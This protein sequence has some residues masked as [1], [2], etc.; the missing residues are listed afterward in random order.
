MLSD[1][2][3]QTITSSQT[4]PIPGPQGVP[5]LGHIPDLRSKGVLQFYLDAWHQFGDVARFKMGPIDM[6]QFV[7]PEHV[8]H[9]LVK[10]ADNY[11]KALSHEKLRVPLGEG[12][13][14]SEGEHWRRQR[15]LMAPTFTPRAVTQF[16]DI[17]LAETQKLM[18]R[19]E[20]QPQG[21]P[22]AINQE[23]M[24]FAMS[25]ISRSMFTLDIGEEFSEAGEALSFILEFANKRTISLVDPPLFL[26][27]PMNLALKRSLRRLDGFLYGIIAERR[28][29][30]PGDDLLSILMQAKDEQT[31]TVMTDEQL[32]DEVLITFFAGHETTATLLSWAW[33]LLAQHPEPEQRLH[34]E[35]D[36]VLGGRSP[37]V[38]DRD[39]LVY[40]GMVLGE[41]LRLYS[42][43][44]VMAR[45]TVADDQIDG[46]AIPAG[47]MVTITPYITHRHPEFWE[48]PDAFYPE[49]F[50]P[51]A[52]DARHRYAYYPF[53]A[54][55]RVCLGK[56]FALLEATLALAELAQRYHLRLVPGQKVEARWSGTLRPAGD[57]LVTLEPR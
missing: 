1:M 14:T 24:R 49:H 52:V 22:I 21:Q 30:P 25:V 23:M 9:I 48:R 54:G 36:R 18:R 41:T 56:H 27:T 29:Q 45:D 15:R 40:T 44:A 26:P 12:I 46:Y 6:F 37:A 5:L 43:V 55:P 33:I 53:G 11:I 32:R 42:P 17:M 51:E 13:L 57:V 47:S 2:S 3:T 16:A 31:G 7:R 34:A 20:A 38:E 10:N 28:R 4:K 35:L 50:V 39:D 19:W 8:Q